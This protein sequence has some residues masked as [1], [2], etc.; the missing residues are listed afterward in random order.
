MLGT[1]TPTDEKFCG[2]CSQYRPVVVFGNHP[3]CRDCRSKYDRRNHLLC[4]ECAMRFMLPTS[5]A[6]ASCKARQTAQ[7]VKPWTFRQMAA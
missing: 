6:C 5:T 7:R 2:R 4:P 1:T 3:W